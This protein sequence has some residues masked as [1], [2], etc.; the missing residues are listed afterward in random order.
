MRGTS[1]IGEVAARNDVA[2]FA[3]KGILTMPES[4]AVKLVETFSVAGRITKPERLVCMIGFFPI[5]WMRDFL[6]AC[7]IS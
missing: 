2:T 4:A 7:H 6:A 5:S 3:V 1:T